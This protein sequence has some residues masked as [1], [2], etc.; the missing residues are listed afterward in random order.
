[1]VQLKDLIFTGAVED[2][3]DHIINETKANVYKLE[4][5]MTKFDKCTTIYYLLVTNY[6]QKIEH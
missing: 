5:R 2:S 1:M 4:D 3:A 6:L